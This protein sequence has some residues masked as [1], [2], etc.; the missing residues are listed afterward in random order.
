MWNAKTYLGNLCL[1]F[2]SLFGCDGPGSGGKVDILQCEIAF[3]NSEGMPK[4]FGSDCI[5]TRQ[6]KIAYKTF[7]RL[8]NDGKTTASRK[9]PRS[10]R[11]Q[12]YL[13]AQCK[14]KLS[15]WSEAT[16]AD[17]NRMWIGSYPTLYLSDSHPL[18]VNL[19]LLCQLKSDGFEKLDVRGQTWVW[20]QFFCSVQ[21][22]I[23]WIPNKH[24]SGVHGLMKLLLATVLPATLDKVIA[25]RNNEILGSTF[26]RLSQSSA[27][28]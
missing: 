20:H 23:E 13:S 3:E 22:E 6:K 21:E 10:A 12:T 5:V 17:L 11:T 26:N 18:S 1:K 28:R 7:R 27:K 24:Y 16:W 8:R 4:T 9:R 19:A 14:R 2:S 15:Y 25:K